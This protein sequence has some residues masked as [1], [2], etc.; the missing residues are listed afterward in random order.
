MYLEL[1]LLL[2]GRESFF[3]A[4]DK[5]LGFATVATQLWQ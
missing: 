1:A 2:F 3:C 5:L 4:L